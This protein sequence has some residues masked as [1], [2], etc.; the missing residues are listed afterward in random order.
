MRAR[1][2]L[3]LANIEIEIRE[4]SLRDK[5]AHM[6]QMSPKGT[7]PVLILAYGTLIDESLEIMLWAFNHAREKNDATGLEHSSVSLQTNIHAACGASNL[8]TLVLMNDLEFKKNLDCYKYPE[9]FPEKTQLEYRQQGELFLQKLE[10]L[11]QQ[12]TYLFGENFSLADIA[13]FPFVRQFAAVDSTWF[14]NAPYV[15]LHVWLNTWLK[16]DLFNDVMQKQ[17]IYTEK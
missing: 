13:I 7:V 3:R 2:A 1:M 14:D 4:I 8:M 15:A 9:R 12:N 10:D 5:P 6:L 17:P 11:L 16:S